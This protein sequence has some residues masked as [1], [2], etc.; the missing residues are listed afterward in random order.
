VTPNNA[1]NSWKAE[2]NEWAET[3]RWFGIC[4]LLPY[5]LLGI[6]A[7]LEKNRDQLF[8]LHAENVLAVLCISWGIIFGSV[9]L[10]SGIAAMK[11][12]YSSENTERGILPAVLG[13]G[14]GLAAVIANIV[15]VFI[16]FPYLFAD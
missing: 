5:L 11:R 7:Y 3:I 12:I 14:F 10:I 13:T 15:T 6:L 16:V 9:T 4:S 8:F 1:A 2:M